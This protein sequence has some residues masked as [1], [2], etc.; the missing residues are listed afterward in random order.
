MDD[1]SDLLPEM[2]VGEKLW[3]KLLVLPQYD[4]SIIQQSPTIRLKALA[5]LYK[6]YIPTKMSVE[7][8]NKLYMSTMM[9]LQKK[10]TKQIVEQQRNNFVG[11]NT[12]Q[13]R[14]NITGAG[15]FTIAGVSGIG[16]SS[17]IARSIELISN[18]R[19]IE[20]TDSNYQKIVP[21]IVV[22]CPS[23]CSR[24]GLLIEILR[25]VDTY[26]GTDYYRKALK[27]G[28][29]ID[30]LI[31]TISQVLIN[32]VG[33]VLVDEIQNVANNR[34]GT[35]LVKMLLQLINCSGVSIGLVGTPECLSFFEK[36]MQFARRAVGLQYSNLNYDEEFYNVCNIMWEFQ[37]VKESEVL[38]EKIVSW[39][40]E[41]TSGNISV[42]ASLLFNAQEIAIINGIE[43]LSLISLK[44]AYESRLNLLHRY[45]EESKLSIRRKSTK[46]K[47]S[48]MEET[49][50]HSTDDIVTISQLYYKCKEEGT[51]FINALRANVSVEE[52]I[53]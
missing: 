36:E 8:Y 20:I 15:S 5:D 32:N 30:T 51:N 27:N 29:T 22:Q 37:Y 9:S 35:Q 6:I 23:D 4:N 44:E 33:L 19:V 47:C 21:C 50:T 11:M 24:K 49:Y 1:Y 25:N 3:E 10:G 38:D 17:S 7:I 31:G 18:N 42:L 40:Y 45:I 43:K 48:G 13:Y 2:L 26:L 28:N 53:L 46:S 34:N 14:G 16:K 52:V 41:H 39:L 12:N